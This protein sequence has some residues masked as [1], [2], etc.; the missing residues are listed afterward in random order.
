MKTIAQQLNIKDFPFEIKDKQGNLLYFEDSDGDCCR[1]EFDSVGNRIY[2]EASS[3][4]IKDN[5]PKY[6]A[7]FNISYWGGLK[8]KDD[9]ITIN[10]I[11]YKRIDE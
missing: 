3:G 1:W 10:G 9:V 7:E 6:E 2:Y 5:R 8:D 11:R 4:V